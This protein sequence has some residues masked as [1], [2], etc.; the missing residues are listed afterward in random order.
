MLSSDQYS[1]PSIIVILAF[2]NRERGEI[3][4]SWGLEELS[5]YNQEPQ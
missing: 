4:R 2:G 3:S 1:S 5:R